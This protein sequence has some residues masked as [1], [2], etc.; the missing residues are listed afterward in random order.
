M[1]A[2]GG[3]D[4]WQSVMYVVRISLLVSKFLTLTDVLTGLG[5]PI[6]SVLRPVSYTHLDVYKRQM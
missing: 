2:E 1:S 3:A 6:L 5:N 4:S